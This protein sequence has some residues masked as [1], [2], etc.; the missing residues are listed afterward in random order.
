MRYCYRS[1]PHIVTVLVLSALLGDAGAQ[2]SQPEYGI[3]FEDPPAGSGIRR[4]AV[5][6]SR[7]PINRTY[8]ELTP[9]QRAIVHG[10][11]ESIAPGDEPPFPAEGMKPILDA[12][13][14][15]QAKLLVT[16]ELFLIATVEKT[17]EVSSVKAVGSPSPEMT[18]FAAAVVA[19]TKFKP[20][21]CAGQ[22]CKMEFP[23]CYVF[24]VE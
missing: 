2:A 11:Y 24:R 12:V 4:E 17:G 19:L 7:V 14:K 1:L 5:R 22:P 10:W 16:G 23:L 9:E 3:K 20:A 13:R 21:V 8:R 6:G 15:A 18:Q